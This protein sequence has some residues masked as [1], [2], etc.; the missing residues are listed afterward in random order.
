MNLQ[1]FSM[2]NTKVQKIR[3]ENNLKSSSD[4]FYYIVIS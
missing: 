3:E 1:D 4:A 2:V